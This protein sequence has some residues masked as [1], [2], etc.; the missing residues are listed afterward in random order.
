MSLYL[1]LNCINQ[2]NIKN[3]ARKSHLSIYTPG[4]PLFLQINK[5][6]EQNDCT[7][8]V[9]HTDAHYWQ[10]QVI[11]CDGSVFGKRKIYYTAEVAEAAGREWVVGRERCFE[12][13]RLC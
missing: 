7:L 8:F 10:F 13:V 2:K 6:P 11:S 1:A 5:S 4:N 12:Q 9:F 3:N